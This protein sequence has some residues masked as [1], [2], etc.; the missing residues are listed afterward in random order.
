MKADLLGDL[1][2]MSEEESELPPGWLFCMG[3]MDFGAVRDTVMSALTST[4]ACICQ[5]PTAKA[6]VEV[7]TRAAMKDSA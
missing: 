2:Q 6:G 5:R 7:E 3:M 1:M 4:V